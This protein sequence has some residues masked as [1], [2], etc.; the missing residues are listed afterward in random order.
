ME[1]GCATPAPEASPGGSIRE[2]PAGFVRNQ[3]ANGEIA[4]KDENDIE[5]GAFQDEKSDNTQDRIGSEGSHKSL[6]HDRILIVTGEI[7][8]QHRSL[9]RQEAVNMKRLIVN[10]IV[11]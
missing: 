2:L 3:R 7:R 11:V 8:V 4:E 10:N 9:E 6:V 1:P 5:S